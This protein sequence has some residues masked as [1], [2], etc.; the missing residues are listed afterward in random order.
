MAD[1]VPEF[2]VRRYLMEGLGS[3]SF[4][5]EVVRQHLFYLIFDVL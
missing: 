1:G 2:V 3:V 5:R 4:V